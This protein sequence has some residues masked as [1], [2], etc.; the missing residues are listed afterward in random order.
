MRSFISDLDGLSQINVNSSYA[1][2][3]ELRSGQSGPVIWRLIQLS[4]VY[5][6]YTNFRNLRYL[7]R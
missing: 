7:L 1:Y 6:H 2:Y 5:I 3:A 4:S